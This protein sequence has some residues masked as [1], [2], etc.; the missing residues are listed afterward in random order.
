M[1]KSSVWARFAKADES[2]KQRIVAASV[3]EVATGKTTFWLGAPGPMVV[4]TLDQGLEGVVEPFTKNKDIY[5]ASYD[6]GYGVGEEFNH[7]KAIEARDKFVADFEHAI[8]NARTVVWDRES[9]MFSLFA[10]AEFGTPDKY[11]AG[12]PKDWDKLKGTIKRMIAMAKATEINFGI[13]Q[14][15][16]D[17]WAK[18]KM[19]KTG[20]K[21]RDGMDGVS[22]LVHIDLEHTRVDREFALTIGKCRGPG[23]SDLQDRTLGGLT[24]SD[25]AQ[26]VFPDS[27]ESDWE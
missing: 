24:F 2:S 13:I 10:Y 16:R 7:E 20:A 17:E 15:V 23:G 8:Q 3:G 18:G 4:Q 1:A 12:N 19:G 22:A 27:S 14:G 9:D 6:L 21:I 11:A 26:L 25:F 5:V